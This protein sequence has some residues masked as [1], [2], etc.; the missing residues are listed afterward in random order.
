MDNTLELYEYI[1]DTISSIS[2]QYEEEPQNGTRFLKTNRTVITNKNK[3]TS[4]YLRLVCEA[5]DGYTT[6]FLYSK[7]SNTTVG[8]I[9]KVSLQQI[10]YKKNLVYKIIGFNIKNCPFC[11]EINNTYKLNQTISVASVHKIIDCVMKVWKLQEHD[12][13]LLKLRVAIGK[14]KFKLENIIS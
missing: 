13:F 11:S 4:Y 2:E 9:G 6:L 12:E 14:Q 3:D 10:P 7:F 8:E 5:T 1:K